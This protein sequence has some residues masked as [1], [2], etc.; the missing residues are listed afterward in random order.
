MIRSHP[1]AVLQAVK[2]ARLFFPGC[3]PPLDLPPLYRAPP[4]WGARRE[5][6]LAR[7]AILERKRARTLERLSR[8]T[9][10]E[11]YVTEA[12][13]ASKGTM[14]TLGPSC[15]CWRGALP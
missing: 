4:G 7:K 10:E 6:S 8:P 5:R 12:R 14:D 9:P 2:K 15:P 11:R 3:L 1:R 13:P